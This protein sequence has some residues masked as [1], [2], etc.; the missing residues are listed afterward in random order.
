MRTPNKIK[1]S[2][3]EIFI[4]LIVCFGILLLSKKIYAIE[5]GWYTNDPSTGSRNNLATY[6]SQGANLIL[7][8]NCYF[9]RSGTAAYLEEA[10]RQEIKVWV[11]LRLHALGNNLPSESAWKDFINSFKGYSAVKGWYIADEPEYSGPGY[12]TILQYYQWT[13]EADPN[14]P[15]SIAHCWTVRPEF[16]GVPRPYD[17]LLLDVYPGWGYGAADYNEFNSRVR[18]S[19]KWWRDGKNA[20]ESYGVPIEAVPLGFGNH[21]DTNQPQNG[22]RDLTDMEHKWH[23]YTAI[24]LGYKAVLFWWDMM[25]SGMI[26]TNN[27]MKTLVTNR[28]SEISQMAAEMENSIMN[29]SRVLVSQPTSKLIYRYGANGNRQVILAVNIA[30]WNASDNNGEKLD[31][32]QFTLPSEIHASQVEILDEDRTLTVTNGTFTD[33]FNRFEV[34]AYAF[35]TDDSP[36]QPTLS[37]NLEA[38]PSSGIAPLNNVDLKATVSGTAQG[39][40]NYR[41]DC[42]DDGTW[43]YVFNNIST[44]PRTV[45]DACD[46]ASAGNYTA[47][48]YVERDTATA[49]QDTIVIGVTEPEPKPTVDLKV[50]NSQGPITIPHNSSATL[51]WNTANANNCSASG[52]WSGARPTS[53]STS[54]GSLTSSTTFTLTCNGP[55]GSTSDNV[56]VNVAS[57]PTLSVNLEAIPS[58]GIAPLNNVDLKAT[59]SGTAQGTI[60]YRFD[61]TDDGTWDYVFNNISTNP[62]TVADAC[63]YASAGNYTARV[64]VERDTATAAQDTI[65]I[66]VTEPPAEQGTVMVLPANQTIESLEQT[67]ITINIANVSNLYGFE[68][69]IRYNES[70]LDYVGWQ[71]NDFMDQSGDQNNPHWTNPT[72]SDGSLDNFAATRL[73]P[74]PA[75]S[76]SGA[77]LNIT[78]RGQSTGVST[79]EIENLKLSNPAGND[80]ASNV[81]GGKIEVKRGVSVDIKANNSDGPIEIP[82]NSDATLSWTS[83]GANNCTASGGWSGAKMTSGIESTGELTGSVEYILTCTSANGSS[84]DSIVVNVNQESNPSGKPPSDF[85]SDL[86]VATDGKSWQDNFS[87]TAPLTGVDLMASIKN[88]EL[89]YTFWCDCPN[90]NTNVAQTIE[91]CGQPDYKKDNTHSNPL[92]VENICNY[93]TPGKYSAKVI[94]EKYSASFQDR[95][96]I[97][98]VEDSYEPEKPPIPSKKPGASLYNPLKFKTFGELSKTI[99]N[100]IF[101]TSLMIAFVFL[102]FGA[103]NILTSGG[104]IAKVALG[105]S[106]ILY[107]VIGESIILLSRGLVSIISNILGK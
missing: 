61:C 66:G 19:Y 107:T 37:V 67:T 16:A 54:T 26:Q 79:I 76:G 55:G 2:K 102:L 22:V 58:S 96:V 59:V 56:T 89:N 24:V 5:A 103:F 81:Q 53:G 11:D 42:T 75:L 32:V 99:I 50:N 73:N 23:T 9:N 49:A 77:L 57:Q 27:H 28:F 1:N 18:D 41:F 6:A 52:G 38:I 74:D 92:I 30:R 10:E 95:A 3:I 60:N 106:I 65:V 51:S 45:A 39:T 20:A 70:I 82:F 12:S 4:F 78:F 69:D 35:N 97:K 63:D 72:V 87:G 47:R 105:K 29:D 21:P 86:K 93:D 83:F 8:Y 62:R 104:V 34:H 13:K 46:Y 31:S 90:S 44:N 91:Y 98:V 43:D 17:V 101:Y 14:H 36:S 71:R 100:F 88:C 68:F 15:V 94:I 7:P 25:S 64:Y 40:I 48:V 85:D 80:I 84:S 33:S